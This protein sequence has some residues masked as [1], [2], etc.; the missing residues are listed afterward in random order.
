[1]LLRILCTQEE[2]VKSQLKTGSELPGV[3][4]FLFLEK[5]AD[6]EKR[7]PA[8]RAGQGRKRVTEV[9]STWAPLTALGPN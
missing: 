2:R 4:S 8:E 7:K 9:N 3:P 6:Q 5:K 1:L